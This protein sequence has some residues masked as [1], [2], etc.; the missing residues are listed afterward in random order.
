MLREDVDY[1]LK[2]MLRDDTVSNSP[3]VA[4]TPGGTV[5]EENWMASHPA[6][7]HS[8]STIVPGH[9]QVPGGTPL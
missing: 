6:L 3:H 8:I 7:W 5:P 1:A 4:S 2:D 9:A